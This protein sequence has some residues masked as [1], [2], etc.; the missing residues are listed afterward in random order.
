MR[1]CAVSRIRWLGTNGIFSPPRVATLVILLER[2]CREAPRHVMIAPSSGA[3]VGATSEA[4]PIGVGDCVAADSFICER[5]D[6]PI[7]AAARLTEPLIHSHID[8]GLPAG[9]PLAFEQVHCASCSTLVH[10]FNNECMTTWLEFV[11]ANVCAACVGT[12]APVLGIEWWLDCARPR[13]P[14]EAALR[15][16]AAYVDE[17]ARGGDPLH[18]LGHI[19]TLVGPPPETETQ[20]A[21]EAT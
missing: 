6:C 8:D 5:N 13:S 11:N 16:V 12:L 2:V 4:P 17:W 10:A 14:S 15:K 19:Q 18:A 9:H 21:G 20:P 3:S 7:H 1:R